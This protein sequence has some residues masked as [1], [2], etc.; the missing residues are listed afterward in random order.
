MEG[1]VG[2]AAVDRRHLRA[3]R[4]QVR[5]ELAAVVAEVHNTYRQR[6]A[7]LLHEMGLDRPLHEQFL[8]Y[9]GQVLRG[10]LGLSL[11]TH[12]PVLDEFVTLFPATIE[13]AVA[14]LALGGCATYS[15]ESPASA[16]Q[17]PSCHGSSALAA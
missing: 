3:M 17:V 12:R 6:H 10:D 8:S 5:R 14:A 1:V 15:T 4:A 9:V 16:A 13:L 2:A 11:V 7:Y